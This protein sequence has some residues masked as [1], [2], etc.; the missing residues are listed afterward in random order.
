[1]ASSSNPKR[2]KTIGHKLDKGKKKQKFFSCNFF[3]QKRLEHFAVVQNRRLL[4]ERRVEQ[5]YPEAQAFGEEIERR[6]W[7]QILTYP[8]PATITIV[9]EFYVNDRHF[10]DADE[11]V[12][13]YVRGKRIPFDSAT[14]NFFLGID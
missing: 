10:S 9:H 7:S 6:Q 8:V 1:M 3:S 14:I 4:M 2:I 11:P 5:V 12:L 13:S